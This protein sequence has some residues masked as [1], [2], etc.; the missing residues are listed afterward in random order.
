METNPTTFRNV[1]V[2]GNP[3]APAGTSSAAAPP[4]GTWRDSVPVG[5]HGDECV[6]Q[7]LSPPHNK[8]LED[9]N[10]FSSGTLLTNDVNAPVQLFR[11]QAAKMQ[12][13]NW[14]VEDVG[15]AKLAVQE[16]TQKVLNAPESAKMKKHLAKAEEELAHAKEDL[17]V[18]Q[19]EVDDGH[20]KLQ[21]ALNPPARIGGF[22]IRAVA[23][24]ALFVWFT[25]TLVDQQMQALRMTPD[26]SVDERQALA[27]ANVAT[28]AALVVVIMGAM[29]FEMINNRR[30]G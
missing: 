16:A 20:A 5:H 3:T 13:R 6:Q 17:Q 23:Y 21:A 24:G 4:Q 7:K 14:A 28:V 29:A 30:P 8:L 25:N 27:I 11:T 18:A 9:D 22:G 19:K 26:T 2:M 15:A 12:N 1:R 10:S